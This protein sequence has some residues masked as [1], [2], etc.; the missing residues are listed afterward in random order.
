MKPCAESGHRGLAEFESGSAG[1]AGRAGNRK[2]EASGKRSQGGSTSD[3]VGGVGAEPCVRDDADVQFVGQC[4][5]AE[6]S[7]ETAD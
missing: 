1:I 4:Y 6:A 3:A 7:C 2:L 5:F